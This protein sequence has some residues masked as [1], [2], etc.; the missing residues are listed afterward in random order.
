MPRKARK[1]DI[2]CPNKECRCYNK[3][4][5]LNIIRK[6]KQNNGTQRYQCT[7]C[8]RTFART[9]NTPFFRKQLK[10]KE[11]V[12][13]CKMLSEKTS[14]RAIARITNHHLDTIRAIADAVANHCKKFNDYFI[15]ELKLSP[16][17]VDEMWSFVKKKK[18]T[19]RLIIAKKGK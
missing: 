5:L 4:N 10:K 8:K 14:F 16:V 3:K 15:Q 11:I 18:K 6:G 19:A 9:I 12:N 1:L 17:E 13:I 2:I 7:D